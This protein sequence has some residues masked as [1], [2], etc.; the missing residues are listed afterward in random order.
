MRAAS[1]AGAHVHSAA[2][3]KRSTVAAKWPHQSF[4]YTTGHMPWPSA[5][6]CGIGGL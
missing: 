5:A 6:A 4:F 3:M 2:V 1:D